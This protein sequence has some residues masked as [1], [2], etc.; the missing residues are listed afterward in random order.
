VPLVA[1]IFGV[2]SIAAISFLVGAVSSRY[3]WIFAG[4]LSARDTEETIATQN[5]IANH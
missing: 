1:R 3:G 5:R 2:V 4:R